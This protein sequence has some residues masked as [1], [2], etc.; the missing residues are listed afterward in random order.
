ME[1]VGGFLGIFLKTVLEL[2]S[3]SMIIRQVL[4]KSYEM[5]KYLDCWFKK[6]TH[7]PW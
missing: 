2:S 6:E 7:W 1:D 4:P 3:N 5:Q